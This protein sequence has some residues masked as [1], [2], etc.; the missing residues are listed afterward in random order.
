MH[1]CAC[2]LAPDLPTS[3]LF[4]AKSLVHFTGWYVN[5]LASKFAAFNH[6]SKWPWAGLDLLPF[7]AIYLL[8]AF[9]HGLLW[10]YCTGENSRCSWASCNVH[11]KHFLGFFCHTWASHPEAEP[12]LGDASKNRLLSSLQQIETFDSKV[13]LKYK[14]C[15]TLDSLPYSGK[16]QLSL[17]DYSVFS[18]IWVVSCKTVQKFSRKIRSDLKLCNLFVL[19]TFTV[20]TNQ[21]DRGLWGT[22][23]HVLKHRGRRALSCPFCYEWHLPWIH[24]C[25]VVTNIYC[26]LHE[27]VSPSCEFLSLIISG[28]S[29]NSLGRLFFLIHVVQ[30]FLSLG[31]FSLLLS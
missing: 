13:W 10:K 26:I 8:L 7:W 15:V 17:L 9:L 30:T 20:R 5:T 14:V 12:R 19:V 24:A 29:V 21:G 11:K 31:Y 1:L 28:S 27:C 4:A 22:T 18:N 25:M 2:K 3:Y 16:G 6:I 23:A